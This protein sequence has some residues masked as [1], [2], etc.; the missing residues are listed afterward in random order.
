MSY[1]RTTTLEKT[2]LR[3]ILLV[4]LA[5]FAICLSGKLAIP[6]WFTP[7]PIATQN[8]VVLILAAL[9][10]ARRG[11]AATFLF[12]LQGAMG[13]PVFSTEGGLHSFFGPTGGYRIGYLI[14]AFLVGTIAEK[15]KTLS[16]AFLAMTVGNLVIYF[17]GASYLSTFVGVGKALLLGVVPFVL[18]DF[19][20]MIAGLNILRWMG[21]NK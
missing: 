13:L 12:L 7:V 19:L 3:D 4:I 18:G 14:A 9:L 2:I 1:A 20:K 16:N 8:S 5:S 11:A 17:C 21:W 10:G 15:N 6:L